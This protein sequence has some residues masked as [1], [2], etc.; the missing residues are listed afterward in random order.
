M[1]FI[2]E[3]MV[4]VTAGNG[5][6]GCMSFRREKYIPLGGPDGGDGGRGG[7]VYLIAQDGMTTLTDFRY[8]RHFKS[9]SGQ[10]GMGKQRF[11]KSGED[12]FVPVPAG[13]IV[14]DHNTDE[15]L[16]DL[17]KAGQTL[18]VAQGGRPGLGNVHFKSSTTRAPR[19]VT[20]GTQGEHRILRMEL[21]ILA[22]VGLLG[23]P[24]AG[25]ST[26]IRAV[27]SATPKVAS[28]PFTT[29][30]PNL[31][32]VDVGQ[33]RSFVMADI[34]G[35]ISGAANGMGLGIQFLK[36]L[37]RTNVLL[38]VLDIQPSDLT[39]PVETFHAIA[40][41]LAKYP[42]DLTIK[43]RWL[44]LNQLDKLP[45][46]EANALCDE[47]IA[48][49]KWTGPAYRISAIARQGVEQLCYDIMNSL[50]AMREE[51]I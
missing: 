7:S 43:P 21:K 28:Y 42:E 47:I 32:V 8:M 22:D 38:H 4:Q 5:G 33:H 29:L 17:V 15:M 14:Y 9:E 25:K 24:N 20:K 1:K 16:G 13:T 44:V 36:H 46:A 45:A 19:K 37:S 27:S 49:L 31:G 50:E 10:G 34:P 35:L 2:D 3:V 11:G 23:A 48:R 39:D 6:H 41:E 40:D 18:L 51:L 12:L 26:L 30:H